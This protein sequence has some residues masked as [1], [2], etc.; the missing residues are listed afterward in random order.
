MDV[1]FRCTGGFSLYGWTISRSAGCQ[2]PLVQ[3]LYDGESKI[4]WV[5]VTRVWFEYIMYRV[6]CPSETLNG[7]DDDGCMWLHSHFAITPRNILLQ[8]NCSEEIAVTV[9]PQ[10]HCGELWV[11]KEL[12]VLWQPVQIWLSLTF[13][14]WNVYWAGSGNYILQKHE[15]SNNYKH[16][17]AS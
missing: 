1:F 4:A 2:C 12:F 9:N 6:K 15:A 5:D 17:Y 14:E 13:S 7:N 11:T 16:R 3:R 10:A 8:Y